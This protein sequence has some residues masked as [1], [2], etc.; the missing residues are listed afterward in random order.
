MPAILTHY[1]AGQAVL[2]S[3]APQI[4]RKIRPC[5][6][7]YNLGTQGPDIFFYYIPGAMRKHTRGIGSYMHQNDLG[8]FL[9]QMAQQAKAAGPLVDTA[10]SGRMRALPVVEFGSLPRRQDSQSTEEPF[11]ESDD[12]PDS[13]HIP[14]EDA[15]AKPDFDAQDAI[16][17]YTAG[18]I[19][20]YAVDSRTHPYVYAKTEKPGASKI[21]NS[22]CHHDF[23]A[24]IDIAM[25]MRHSGKKPADCKLWQLINADP[26]QRTAASG[27]VSAAIDGVYGRTVSQKEVRKAMGCMVQ[28]VRLIQS[29]KGRRKKIM[30]A[31]ERLFL[32]HPLNASIIH[33]QDIDSGTDYLNEENQ[34]WQAP[35]ENTDSTGSFLDLYQA[36]VDEGLEIVQALYDYVYGSLPIETLQAKLGNRSLKTGRECSPPCE[37]SQ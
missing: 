15:K 10:A 8:H 5:E 17:A 24:A 19:M 2:N 36:A 22:T 16:F 26:A 4:S 28:I 6:Q 23:E 3:L 30:G 33:D 29:R 13:G 31:A 18:F 37:P 11:Q 1:I 7:L 21:E 14:A 9:V 25:L 20:H 32:G 35:W 27:A 12:Y 34:P